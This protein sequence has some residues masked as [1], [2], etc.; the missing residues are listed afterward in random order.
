MA[1]IRIKE[2]PTSRFTILMVD[3]P[4]DECGANTANAGYFGKYTEG[5]A[6]FTLP[7]GH[8][9][10]DFVADSEW[11]R[12]YCEERG[13]FD[14][15][16]FRFDSSTW[17]YQNEFY[18]KAIST[19]IVKNGIASIVDTTTLPEAD[20]AIAGVPVLRNGEDCSWD[21]YVTK[22]G[23]GAATVRP[24]WHNFVGLKDK[25]D[26]VYLV[27][28]KTTTSNMISSSEAFNAL[29]GY[30]FK[31]VIKVDGGGS[32]YADYDSLRSDTGGARRI[33]TIFAFGPKPV[34]SGG[35]VARIAL[36]A[37]HG[38]NTPGRRCLKTLDPNETREWVLNDRICDKIEAKLSAYDDYELLRMDDSDDGRD[39]VALGERVKA[40]NEWGADVYI[41][42]HHNAGI[43]GGAGG[44]IVAYTYTK[45]LQ[46]S[47]DWRDELYEELI[48][49]TGLRGNRATPK[50]SANHY[51]TRETTMPA[52]LLELGFMD[53]RTDVPI[54]L[55]EDYAEHC[56]DAIVSVL[57]RRFGLTRRLATVPE[58]PPDQADTWAAEAW[59][60]ASDVGVL[61]GTRPKAPVSRQELAAVLAKLGLV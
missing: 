7:S 13:S 29:K 49:R 36:S 53:S 30:G 5:S 48:T 10:C 25:D 34:A 3:R 23:W 58:N 1:N 42:V 41:S 32:F 35:P 61:D 31:D 20:Y 46:A 24:T 50:A 52:V 45:A 40:A 6:E 17:S 33:N 19:L 26:V 51:V 22:Q 47:L 28:M 55:S 60:R 16:K 43:N 56:A 14:G 2:I 11:T 39:D 38:I 59:A 4:K 27:S 18:G 57:A 37:G 21:N 15:S 9:I 44:G 54:I 8:L 12:H